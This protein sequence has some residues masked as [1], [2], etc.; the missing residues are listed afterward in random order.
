MT[1]LIGKR[2]LRLKGADLTKLART[3]RHRP[4]AGGF[5]LIEV[6]V[7]V[8]ILM[9]GVIVIDQILLVSMSRLSFLEHRFEA[10]RLL[11]NK[12]WEVQDLINRTGAAPKNFDDSVLMGNERVYNYAMQ[13]KPVGK[14]A[15]LY[16][17][18]F[19]I[20]WTEAG[21]TKKIL[22]SYYFGIP[23]EKPAE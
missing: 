23:Y 22:R 4:S 3:N 5:T 11:T 2:G 16:Q 19:R 9:A 21:W 12:I 15:G 7:S 6:L 8:V 17:A 1:S 20:A 18:D 13:S 14:T 10:N